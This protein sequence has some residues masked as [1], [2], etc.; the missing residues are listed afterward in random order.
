MSSP[1][2]SVGVTFEIF[3]TEDTVK[4]RVSSSENLIK[5]GNGKT[6]ADVFR[7]KPVDARGVL[8]GTGESDLDGEVENAFI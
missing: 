6:D 5:K 3:D 1:D 4:M 8:W 7:T 2:E